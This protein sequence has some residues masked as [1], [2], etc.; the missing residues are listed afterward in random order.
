VTNTGLI[1]TVVDS[2]LSMLTTINNAL[3]S[4]TSNWGVVSGDATVSD[5]QYWLNVRLTDGT[6]F[7]N[8][9][10][11]VAIQGLVNI[12]SFG[13]P[14]FTTPTTPNEV[15][16]V[17]TALSTGGTNLDVTYFDISELL[18]LEVHLANLSSGSCRVQIYHTTSGVDSDLSLIDDV[19]VLSTD[20]QHITFKV[21]GLPFK[22]LRFRF[23]P[24]ISGVTGQYAFI[25]RV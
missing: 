3:Q 10:I 22:S 24:T 17:M 7:I 21:N 18:L 25:A 15:R 6:S 16:S 14:V 23:T 2:V 11:P 20:D 1:K 5:P 8:S 9:T 12:G 19:T 4:F 13:G